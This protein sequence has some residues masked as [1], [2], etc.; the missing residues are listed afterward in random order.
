MKT[1]T[2]Q[3]TTLAQAAWNAAEHCLGIQAGEVS[4]VTDSGDPDRIEIARALF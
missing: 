1:E 3:I 4:I 2:S